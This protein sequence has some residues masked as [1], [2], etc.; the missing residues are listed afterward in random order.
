MRLAWL[1]LIAGCDF[2]PDSIKDT[3]PDAPPLDAAFD[4]AVDATAMPGD[5]APPDGP[6]PP[7]AASPDAHPCAGV[8]TLTCGTTLET[9]VCNGHCWIG[10]PEMHSQT[11]VISR[12]TAWGGELARFDSQAEQDCMLASFDPPLAMWIGLTQAAASGATN[13]GWSWNGDGIPPPWTNWSGGQPNDGD[14]TEDDTEQCAY[15]S[16]SNTWQDTVCSAAFSGFACR[17]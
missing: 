1:I 14:G 11:E 15:L 12:C 10:C 4:S 16:T 7:D 9:F 3:P 8:G 6:P 5:S 17:R 2:A 13:A